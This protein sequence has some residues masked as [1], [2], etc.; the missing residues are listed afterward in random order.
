MS[1]GGLPL[2]V[3]YIQA[4][5]VPIMLGIVGFVLTSRQV[6]IARV[7]LQHDL[8]DRRFAVFQT[9]RQFLVEVLV[10]RYVWNDQIR[11]TYVI[12]TA[13]AV[14]LLNDEI[15][16]YLEEI[17]TRSD[18]L[19]TIHETLP[20]VG[21]ARSRLVREEQEIV[22]W[23]TAQLPAGLVTK[24]KPFFLLERQTLWRERLLKRPRWWRRWRFTTKPMNLIGYL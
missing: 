2:W 1:H 9:A 19:T 6:K 17:R 4:L 12:G 10:H 22:D 20:P 14:F 24:F 13:D 8:Y 11:R 23:L 7:R 21:D 16:E 3:Q 15:V 18:R 5:G